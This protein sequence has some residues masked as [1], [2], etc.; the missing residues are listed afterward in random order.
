MGEPSYHVGRPFSNNL[1]TAQQLKTASGSAGIPQ[2]PNKE[3]SGA[4][5]SPW[6]LSLRGVVTGEDS[7]RMAMALCDCAATAQKEVCKNTCQ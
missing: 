1:G 4:A 2:G 6:A 7:G 5:F 3:F